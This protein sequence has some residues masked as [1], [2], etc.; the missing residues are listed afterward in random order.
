[1]YTVHVQSDEKDLI[2]KFH[3]GPN[4]D[5]CQQINNV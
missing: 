5:Y 1:M 2:A 4:H 3:E